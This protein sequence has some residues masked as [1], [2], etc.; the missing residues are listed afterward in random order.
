MR[1]PRTPRRPA[2]LL[3]RVAVLGLAGLT[4][5]SVGGLVAAHVRPGL[6]PAPG[7]AS[8]SHASHTSATSTTSTTTTLAGAGS[9][10]GGPVISSLEPPSGHA[11]DQVTVA[12]SRLYSADG[13]IVVTFD[14]NPAPTHCPSEE[15]CIV[16]VPPPP[17]GSTSAVVRLET[18]TGLSNTETFVYH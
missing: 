14:G 7:V 3:L 2:P 17:R 13:T 15:R 9:T 11:G 12:G 1:P 8:G 10:A 16:T 4:L 18:P 6:V 5:A